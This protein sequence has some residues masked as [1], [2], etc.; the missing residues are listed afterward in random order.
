[1]TFAA[2]SDTGRGQ[3]PGRKGTSLNPTTHQES[4]PSVDPGSGERQLGERLTRRLDRAGARLDGER[5]R[6]GIAEVVQ[7]RRWWTG[8]RTW[9]PSCPPT[10]VRRPRSTTS[11]RRCPASAAPRRSSPARRRSSRGRT[12]RSRCRRRGWRQTRCGR[13]ARRTPARRWTAPVSDAAPIPPLSAPSPISNTRGCCQE[14]CPPTE[15]AAVAARRPPAA[16][17]AHVGRRLQRRRGRHGRQSFRVPRAPP[18]GTRGHRG[19]GSGQRVLDRRR[20]RRR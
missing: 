16:R 19:G 18:R 5:K 17:V 7:A 6:G 1:M 3:R 20:A 12:P 10:S 2:R 8:P 14:R 15:L 11:G 9:R 4:N 13:R